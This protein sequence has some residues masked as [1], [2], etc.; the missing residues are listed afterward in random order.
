MASEYPYA[1]FVKDVLLWP[2]TTDMDRLR[3][4]PAVAMQLGGTA[5]LVVRQMT[6]RPGG[7]AEI[8][9]G[10]QDQNGQY[11]TGLMVRLSKS[12]FQ[13]RYPLRL[14]TGL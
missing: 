7:Y 4:G 13:Q 11:T 6:E 14:L 9:Q 5:R 12:P 2:L 3:Q 10:R 1:S 8:Q